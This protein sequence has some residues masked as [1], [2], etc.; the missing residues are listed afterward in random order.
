MVFLMMPLFMALLIT[1]PFYVFRRDRDGWYRS[2]C[3]VL[4]IIVILIVVGT[5]KEGM[6]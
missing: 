4:A 5:I 1:A 2:Y 6:F 3:I